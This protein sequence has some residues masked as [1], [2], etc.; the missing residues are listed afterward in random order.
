MVDGI[1]IDLR[2]AGAGDTVEKEGLESAGVESGFDGVEGLALDGVQVVRLADRRGT[3]RQ[4]LLFQFDHSAAG[5][6]AGGGTT[7]LD[8]VFDVGQVVGTGME[9]EVGQKLAL[10]FGM[11]ALRGLACWQEADAELGGRRAQGVAV[12][13]DILDGDPAAFF[14]GLENL[15]RKRH[16]LGQ[17]GC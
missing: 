14:E 7:V 16:F 4:F 13:L 11:L 17:V 15:G 10:G 8:G 3:N 12:A 5:Q 9:R 6:D 2:L 1:E